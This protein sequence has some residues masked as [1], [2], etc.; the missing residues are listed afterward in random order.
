MM[1]LYF[2]SSSKYKKILRVVVG[3]RNHHQQQREAKMANPSTTTGSSPAAT[4]LRKTNST[5]FGEIQRLKKRIFFWTFSND[6]ML[7]ASAIARQDVARLELPPDLIRDDGSAEQSIMDLI[8]SAMR[9]LTHFHI[10]QAEG[11]LME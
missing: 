4:M 2:S 8:H 5:S 1:H 10:M 7:G 9:Q 11:Q 3:V 6:A